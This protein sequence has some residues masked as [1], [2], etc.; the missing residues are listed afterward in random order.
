M[1]TQ[2]YFF[3]TIFNQHISETDIKHHEK[4]RA[5]GIVLDV[6]TG[7]LFY[8][9][10]FQPLKL[11]FELVFVRH[12]ETYGN[13][14]QSTASGA[15]DLSLVSSDTKNPDQRIFQGDVDTE[16]NQLT[17][18][19]KSQ[20]DDAALKLEKE[21]LRENWVPNIILHSPL[22]RAKMTGL[23]FV[24]R[25]NFHSIYVSHKGIREMSFGSWDNRRVCDFKPTDSC[26]TFYQTQH[27]LVRNTSNDPLK[28]SESFCDLLQRAHQTL[29]E[30]ND[31]YP[32][33]KIIMFSHSMFGAA[34]CILLGKGQKIE[35]GEY[36][37]FDGKR[38]NGE[39]YTMPHAT[40]FHLNL[41]LPGLRKAVT[42]I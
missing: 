27:A 35:N 38:S 40:P 41:E 25:N 13:C 36:L 9:K 14:G 8:S 28:S 31:K 10:H 3:S 16:I 33:A 39:S 26:H 34:C 29:M 19:G 6:T 30:L 4:L 7:H 23:P 2:S 11:N 17:T 15:I 18:L 1:K 22:S 42:R 12:G 37:A 21:L 20:A 24:K 5:L 32:N